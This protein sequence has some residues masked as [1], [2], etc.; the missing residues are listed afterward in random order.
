[1]KLF[2]IVHHIPLGGFFMTFVEKILF[3]GQLFITFDSTVLNPAFI[4]SP[5]ETFLP[6][7]SHRSFFILKK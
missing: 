5:G 3:L 7:K 1:M 4:V 2:E 6:G